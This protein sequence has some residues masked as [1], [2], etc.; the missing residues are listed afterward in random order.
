M[1][2]R[3]FAKGKECQLRIPGICN[4]NPET[5]VLC[6]LRL[7][8][9]AGVGQKPPDLCAVHACSGC[10]DALDGRTDASGKMW[11]IEDRHSDILYALNRTLALVSKELGL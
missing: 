11:A 4:H 9:V 1:N 8:N 3:K 7:G 2:L 10:H 5:T 6:H